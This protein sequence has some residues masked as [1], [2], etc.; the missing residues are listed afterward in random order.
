MNGKA[1]AGVG[2]TAE[3]PMPPPC[4]KCGHEMVER[5]LAYRCPKCKTLAQKPGIDYGNVMD[6]E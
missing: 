2:E 1:G 4:P 3:T 5:P 6:D